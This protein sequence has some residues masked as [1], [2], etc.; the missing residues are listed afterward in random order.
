MAKCHLSWT[1]KWLQVVPKFCEGNLHCHVLS[2]V[3]LAFVAF[4][5]MPSSPT[6]PFASL[7]FT[8]TW[9]AQR[10]HESFSSRGVPSASLDQEDGSAV[11]CA[12][13]AWWPELG[14]QTLHSGRG[15]P[16]PESCFLISTYHFDLSMLFWQFWISHEG[17]CEWKMDF[18]FYFW[19][20]WNLRSY[21]EPVHHFKS[22]GSLASS[23]GDLAVVLVAC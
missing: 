7:Q 5:C 8:V 11:K 19:K 2:T 15:E 20:N 22:C 23:A 21:S 17:L 1:Q 4:C 6:P 10:Y 18:F 14:P 16:T 3:P 9:V 13:Q 12:C